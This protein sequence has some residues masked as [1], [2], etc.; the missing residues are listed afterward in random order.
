MRPYTLAGGG[1][2]KGQSAKNPAEPYGERLQALRKRRGL[3]QAELA[4]KLGLYDS[5]IAQYEGGYIR[6]HASL[7]VRLAAAL[8]SSPNELLGSEPV[9]SDRVI[10]NR[11]LLRRFREVDRLP[12]A[13]QKMLARFLDGLL[14]RHGLDQERPSRRTLTKAAKRSRT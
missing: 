4:K 5:L 12:K 8:Q 10:R 7:I 2:P 1:V 3:T 13:D 11:G 14:A 6:L 9:K